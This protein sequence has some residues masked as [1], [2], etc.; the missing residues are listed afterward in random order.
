VPSGRRPVGEVMKEPCPGLNPRRLV[1]L[2]RDAIQR[3]RLNLDGVV[4]LTEAATGAYVVTPVLA[5]MA[6]ARHVCA[7]TRPSRYGS[8]E[9]VTVATMALGEFA[10]VADRLSIYTERHQDL[11]CQADIVTNSGHVRPLDATAISWMRPTAVIPLMYE[12]WEFRPADVDLDACRRRGIPVGGTNER[13]P[14]VDVFGFLGLMAVKLLTDAGVSAYRGRI[15]LLCDNPFL[16][17]I[18]RGL[19]SAGA[20]VRVVECLSDA[21]GDETYDAV[22]VACQPRR[23]SALSRADVARLAAS[24]PGAVV[25]QFWGDVDRSALIDA[26]VP[27]WPL[28][29]LRP[30]HM[31]ILPSA[32]GPEVIVRLQA[33]GLKAAEILRRLGDNLAPEERAFVEVL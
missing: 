8:V 32:V 23:E 12:A 20:A 17:F 2:M 25:A 19:R 13:H 4:V 1:T 14:A 18:E 28:D 3:C 24:W 10:G 16:P 29:P 30:G 26:G 11:F 22:M 31:G 9:D 6:G 33:G 27:L 21:P 15:L 7:L 5:A